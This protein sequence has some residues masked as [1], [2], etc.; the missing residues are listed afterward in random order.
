VLRSRVVAEITSVADVIETS[1]PERGFGG[2]CN[3]RAAAAGPNIA[4]QRF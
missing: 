2:I 3:L 4:A 1:P